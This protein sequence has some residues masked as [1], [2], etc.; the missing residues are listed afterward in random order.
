L[1]GEIGTWPGKGGTNDHPLN[2]TFEADMRISLFLGALAVTMAIPLAAVAGPIESACN[3]SD[4]AGATRAMCRCID[5]VAQQTLTRSEQQR[6]ARFFSN[7]Q[8]AQDVRM[9][10]TR[11]DNEFWA[12][13]RTFGE[14]AEASCTR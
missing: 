4:R 6:A 11:E 3:R 5:S 1:L 14:R 13:Y 12:R 7:P 9:S 10:R 2:Q 8:L